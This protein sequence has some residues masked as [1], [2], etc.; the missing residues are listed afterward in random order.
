MALCFADGD[1]IYEVEQKQRRVK[2][3]LQTC[4]ACT[5]MVSKVAVTVP[6]TARE[7]MTPIGPRRWLAC[8]GA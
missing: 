3:N 2:V 5:P 4:V 1:T 6:T 7:L 8:K